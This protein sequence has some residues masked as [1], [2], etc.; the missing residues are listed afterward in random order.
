MYHTSK[1][2]RLFRSISVEIQ[3]PVVDDVLLNG[4]WI[5]NKFVI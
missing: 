3:T 1:N 2:F 4:Y 5:Q